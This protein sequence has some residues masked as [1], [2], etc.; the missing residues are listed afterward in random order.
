[1][2]RRMTLAFNVI[3]C[4]ILTFDVTRRVTL[5]RHLFRGNLLRFASTSDYL[6]FSRSFDILELHNTAKYSIYPL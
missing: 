3:R 2:I 1:M 4:M 5:I 6:G